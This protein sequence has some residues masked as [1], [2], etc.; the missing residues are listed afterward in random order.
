MQNRWEAETQQRE[1]AAAKA[2]VLK[3][4]SAAASTTAAAAAGRTRDRWSSNNDT[5]AQP[6]N[7]QQSSKNLLHLC[8]CLVGSST[9][10]EVV[11]PPVVDTQT[12]PS[13]RFARPPAPI[14]TMVSPPPS[15]SF[16][17]TNIL[18]GPLSPRATD[19]KVVSRPPLAHHK[20]LTNSSAIEALA[21]QMSL[22]SMGNTDASVGN[23]QPT[24]LVKD[25]KLTPSSELLG[26]V[27]RAKDSKSRT[28]WRHPI[29]NTVSRFTTSNE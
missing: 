18:S 12:V 14:D 7:Q 1:A 13:N 20:S 2:Q 19:S 11:K 9:L 28:C 10:V 16:S 27:T 8:T 25:T 5:S 23:V 22:S 26:A 17:Q 24:V 3:P 29:D 6:I 21:R 4:A 15:P